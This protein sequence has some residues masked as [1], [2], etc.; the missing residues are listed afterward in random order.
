MPQDERPTLRVEGKDDKYVIE[1]LL[2]RHGIDPKVF[3]IRYSEDGDEDAGG[4][5]SLLKGMRTSVIT[6]TG[7]SVGFVL[8]ADGAA[9][10][11]WRAVRKQLAG[12][13]LDLPD[14][15]PEGG[16]I[17]DA[18]DVQARVGVWLMLD[19]RRPGALEEFLRD[20]VNNEDALLQHAEASTAE[21]LQRGAGFPNAKQRKAVLH[22][23]LAWQR[24]P[25]LP[26]GLAITAHYFKH[27]TPAALA[28]VN[29]FRCVFETEPDVSERLQS[30][31]LG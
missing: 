16:F 25:G 14:E 31:A 12:L 15:I 8:D 21:A 23:W 7:N 5:N 19:N 20:L 17:G 1:R 4:Q 26:Y 30:S 18:L 13:E 27:D 9:T 11:R 10:D 6:S 2:L 3:D 29:W 24:R 28:F 22:A